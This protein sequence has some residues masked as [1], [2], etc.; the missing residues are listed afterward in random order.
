M[1][2]S[3]YQSSLVVGDAIVQLPTGE[4]PLALN[5]VAEGIDRPLRP[6]FGGGEP[7]RE[8][9]GRVRQQLGRPGT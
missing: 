9:L 7:E 4:P 6:R 8:L 5:L 3:T 1:V 2:F